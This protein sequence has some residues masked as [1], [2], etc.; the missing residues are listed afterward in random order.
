MG[1]YAG[2]WG[3]G[4]MSF[5]QQDSPVCWLLE[6]SS[7]SLFLDLWSLSP[8][9]NE[10]EPQGTPRCLPSSSKDERRRDS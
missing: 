10:Q 7:F 3:E 5:E 1:P 6:E 8:Q 9:D 4:R 2:G